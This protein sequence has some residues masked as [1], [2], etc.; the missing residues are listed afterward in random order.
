MI[1]LKKDA[2]CSDDQS[3]G[4]NENQSEIRSDFKTVNGGRAELVAS[5][6]SDVGTGTRITLHRVTKT[7]RRITS[8]KHISSVHS[9]T[10]T[11]TWCRSRPGVVTTAGD[12][13][14]HAVFSFNL[15]NE[16]PTGSDLFG[17]INDLDALVKDQNVG[18]QEEQIRADNSGATNCCSDNNVAAIKN[19]LSNEAR[20]ENDKS[21]SASDSAAGLELLNICHRPSFSHMEASL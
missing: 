16:I 11:T 9:S 18:L 8:G 12:G 6:L 21:P 17:W 10:V 7:S 14:G 13:D 3:S 1:N 5:Q 4:S 19:S 2:Y 20:K 15:F